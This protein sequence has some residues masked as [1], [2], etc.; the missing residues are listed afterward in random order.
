MINGNAGAKKL[1]EAK[2][3]T[4]GVRTFSPAGAKKLQAKL[5]STE[6]QAARSHLVGIKLMSRLQTQF[7]SV[8]GR[9]SQKQVEALRERI[10]LLDA[11][12]MLIENRRK[13]ISA[14]ASKFKIK[15]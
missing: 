7:A 3:M 1:A 9:G 8:K 6:A 11:N 2:K 15:L 10:R 14:I 5:V 13:D 12:L 4:H